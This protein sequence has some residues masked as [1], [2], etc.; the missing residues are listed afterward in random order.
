MPIFEIFLK[1]QLSPADPEGRITLTGADW[2]GFCAVVSDTPRAARQGSGGNMACQKQKSNKTFEHRKE[3][4]AMIKATCEGCEDYSK[5]VCG[6]HRMFVA[7][8]IDIR[9]RQGGCKLL[10]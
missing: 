10:L 2:H 9:M 1:N 4:I 3:Q 8:L 7:F 6:I 5:K